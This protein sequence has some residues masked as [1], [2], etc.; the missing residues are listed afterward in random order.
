M[1]SQLAR[2]DSARSNETLEDEFCPMG[3]KHE[4]ARDWFGTRRP[5]KPEDLA[6]GPGGPPPTYGVQLLYE[7]EP[8]LDKAVLLTQ[9]QKNCGAVELKDE[10]GPVFWFDFH[11]FKARTQFFSRRDP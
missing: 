2:G 8:R 1:L 4:W 7:R 9:L 3:T 5:P 10:G 6:E 11:D